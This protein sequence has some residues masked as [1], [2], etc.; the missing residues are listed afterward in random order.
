[1]FAADLIYGDQ[2]GGDFESNDA[3]GWFLATSLKYKMDLFTPG[4][5]AWYGSGDDDDVATDGAGTL[6]IVSPAGFA[7]TSFGFDGAAGIMKDAILSDSGVGMWGV[8]LLAEDIQ[9][10]ED[11]T[12]TVRIAYFQGTNDEEAATL[13]YKDGML[14]DEDSG[15]EI[16]FDT[17][18]QIYENLAAAIEL[19]WVKLDL[20]EDVW[21]DV[22]EED[23]WKAGINL[24]YSF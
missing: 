8:A 12:H 2:D 16:N 19:G 4:I 10:I 11:V 13:N 6:P 15:W 9:F 23:A 18:Y 20:E 7:P 14:S 21:G 1:M 5:I 24:T 22:D 17:H 3:S